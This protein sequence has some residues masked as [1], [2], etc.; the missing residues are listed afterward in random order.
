[1]LHNAWKEHGISKSE[2]ARVLGV[3]E[4]EARRLL[5]PH[6]GIKLPKM[7]EAF[8]ALGKRIVID[9]EDIKEHHRA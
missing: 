4:K 5:D 6:Y 8:D 3:D 2:F 7:A 9:V 1:M